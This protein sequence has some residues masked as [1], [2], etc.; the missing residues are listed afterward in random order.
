MPCSGCLVLLQGGGRHAVLKLF[1]AVSG[2]ARQAAVWTAAAVMVAAA[3]A[4]V[5]AHSSAG[6][7]TSYLNLQRGGSMVRVLGDGR[8]AGSVTCLLTNHG[9]QL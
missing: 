7:T 1:K 9:G 8:W 6:T 2:E 5:P 3:M 4:A